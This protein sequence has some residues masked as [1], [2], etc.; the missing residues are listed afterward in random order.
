MNSLLPIFDLVII[1]NNEFII[2]V[3]IANN[4]IV[5]IGNNDLLTDVII[6][7]NE[8]NNR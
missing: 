6:G 8:C 3:I 4:G 2:T 7:N 5:I 1:G